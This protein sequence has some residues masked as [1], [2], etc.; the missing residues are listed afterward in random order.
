MKVRVRIIVPVS[1]SIGSHHARYVTDTVSEH[2]GGGGNCH[3]NQLVQGFVTYGPRAR[4]GPQRYSTQPTVATLEAGAFLTA[5]NAPAHAKIHPPQSAGAFT[6]GG[7][8]VASCPLG[9]LR[10]SGPGH[11]VITL[12]TPELDPP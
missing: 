2:R 3:A 12:L 9:Y 7:H 1:P 10:A 4:P 11:D 5:V 8:H 6:T